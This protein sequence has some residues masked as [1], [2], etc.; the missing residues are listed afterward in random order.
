MQQA[1]GC[2]ARSQARVL[3][4]VSASVGNVLGTAG[5]VS[6]E[7]RRVA[8]DIQAVASAIR[9]SDLPDKFATDLETGGVSQA[10]ESPAV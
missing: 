6:V 9:Q 2:R 10:S 1:I 7:F 5:E 8:Y 4:R 3:Q